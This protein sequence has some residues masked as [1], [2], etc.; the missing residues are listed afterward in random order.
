ML[1]TLQVTAGA[2]PTSAGPLLAVVKVNSQEEVERSAPR[3]PNALAKLDAS[4]IEEIHKR[5]IAST[6]CSAE[7]GA[8]KFFSVSMM[9][10]PLAVR[11]N[12]A[13]EKDIYF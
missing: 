9:G 8:L 1:V 3:F 12:R 2:L 11:R 13:H 6:I 10:P 5:E 4:K 7:A